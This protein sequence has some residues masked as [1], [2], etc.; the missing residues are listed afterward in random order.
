LIGR[1]ETRVSLSF[2]RVIG[3]ARH[4]SKKTSGR[5]RAATRARERTFFP[6][7][8]SDRTRSLEPLSTPGGTR[9]EMRFDRRTR[10]SPPHEPHG[11]NVCPLPPHA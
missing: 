1:G 5:E 9:S 2:E 3:S 11:V 4:S 10:P 6:A 7:L 8:P